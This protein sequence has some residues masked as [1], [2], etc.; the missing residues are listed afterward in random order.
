M[1]VIPVLE[2]ITS[3]QQ[4]YYFCSQARNSNILRVWNDII[5][6]VS[7]FGVRPEALKAETV[8]NTAASCPFNLVVV[9][10]VPVGR[11]CRWNTS[12]CAGWAVVPCRGEPWRSR[13]SKPQGMIYEP[14]AV[15]FP[16]LA[17]EHGSRDTTPRPSP[18]LLQG[19][20]TSQR[21]A[22]TWN[23]SPSILGLETKQVPRTA[24]AT[25]H[26]TGVGYPLYFCLVA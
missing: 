25:D 12:L 1:K 22:G 18:R 21:R 20:E 26:E 5:L 7:L 10:G 6:S 9:G 2:D 24:T 17:P 13:A 4:S 11:S 19:R 23:S 8:Y 14:P 16:C 3:G 15:P